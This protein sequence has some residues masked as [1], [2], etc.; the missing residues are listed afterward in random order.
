MVRWRWA[1]DGCSGNGAGCGVGNSAGGDGGVFRPVEASACLPRCDVKP[2][3]ACDPVAL[4]AEDR[5][6]IDVPGSDSDGAAACPEAPKTY[7][8]PRPL[9][10]SEKQSSHPWC[11]LRGKRSPK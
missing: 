4:A 11:L 1:C 9:R 2:L 3:S 10:L 8:L 5:S 6:V 7:L